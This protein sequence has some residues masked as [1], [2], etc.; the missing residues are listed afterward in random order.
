MP[1]VGP[2]RYGEIGPSP[3]PGRRPCVSSASDCASGLCKVDCIQHTASGVHCCSRTTRHAWTV[4]IAWDG[5]RRSRPARASPRR[6]SRRASP[7]LLVPPSDGGPGIS[8]LRY[9]PADRVEKPL[10]QPR[11]GGGATE[12]ARRL[13]DHLGNERHG[14]Q[15][16]RKVRWRPVSGRP[17]RHPDVHVMRSVDGAIA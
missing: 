17:W 2:R 1:P 10:A 13:H 4:P 12:A 14:W 8:D 5:E 16:I 3:L 7:Q 9:G 11:Q 6:A 15:R